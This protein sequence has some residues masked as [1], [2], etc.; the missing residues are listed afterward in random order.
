MEIIELLR[1]YQ[2]EE[3]KLVNFV[4]AARHSSRHIETLLFLDL[5]KVTDNR[6]MATDGHRLHICD[7]IG[8]I[9][10]GYYRQTKRT[11]TII[12]LELVEDLPQINWPE[13]VGITGKDLSDYKSVRID[14]PD[15]AGHQATAHG[16]NTARVLRAM[17]EKFTLNPDYL[18]DATLAT[19]SALT[20]Q[21]DDGP[22]VV[23]VGKRCKAFVM[24]MKGD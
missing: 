10:A 15:P 14:P 18:Y 24:P 6:I 19:T 21:E 23:F 1:K 4:L 22:P 3:F 7:N 8:A 11:K 16:W 13:V 17:P 5:V 2:P 12:N 20:S 9:P